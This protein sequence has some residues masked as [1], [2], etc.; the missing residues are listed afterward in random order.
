LINKLPY[1]YERQAFPAPL[2]R[3]GSE[4]IARDL[5]DAAVIA[6][7]VQIMIV[8]SELR[9]QSLYRALGILASIH[10]DARVMS[11]I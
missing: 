10:H 3:I 4:V 7:L 2:Y 6:S 8:A 1:A 5:F 9:A 11:H